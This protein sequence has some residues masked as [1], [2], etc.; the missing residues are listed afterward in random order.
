MRTPL[1]DCPTLKLEGLNGVLRVTLNRPATRNALS[2]DVV[3][4][5]SA[6]ATAL[7]VDQE[8]RVVVLRGSEGNFCAGGNIESFRTLALLPDA[9][10][11]DPLIESNLAF[12][13]LMLRWSTIPQV[14]IA[15]VEGAAF[16]GGLGLLCV[17][18]LVLATRTASFAVS[19]ARIGVVPAQI[20]PFLVGRVGESATR[21]A[22]LTG[23]RF[24]GSAAAAIGLVH[25]LYNDQAELDAAGDRLIADILRCAPS[26][27]ASTK[28]LL[29]HISQQPTEALLVHAATTFANAA[30][31]ADGQEG[32]A[33][34]LEKRSPAWSIASAARGQA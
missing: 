6:L 5:L 20:A 1:P 22:A 33:A 28:A 31:G 21:A 26:A 3:R 29:T 25:E 8:I 13:H 12:G 14:L 10:A 2:D 9:G 18:D 19:E 23:R 15:L 34:F 32:V 17:A 4:D 7:Q 24:D 11:A 27:I 16:G 30:R